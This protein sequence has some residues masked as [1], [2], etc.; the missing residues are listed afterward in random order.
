M[1]T[2]NPLPGPAADLGGISD[3]DLRDISELL[4][5]PPDVSLPNLSAEELERRTASRPPLLPARPPS[6]S[7][8]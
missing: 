6:G 3:E 5:Q 8:R 4:S 1:P 2:K 7:A